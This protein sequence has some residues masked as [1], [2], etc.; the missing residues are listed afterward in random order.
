MASPSTDLSRR[1]VRVLIR[2]RPAQ[3]RKIHP[4]VDQADAKLIE[5]LC[6]E[7]SGSVDTT[8][9]FHLIT[10][11]SDRKRSER[12]DIVFDYGVPLDARQPQVKAFDVKVADSR[13]TITELFNPAIQPKVNETVEWWRAINLK[14][15]INFPSRTDVR[16]K[17]RAPGVALPV[18]IST[19]SVLRNL[20]VNISNSLRHPWY[21]FEI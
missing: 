16:R 14:H 7:L 2:T 8:N 4:S 9:I 19:F 5:K 3:L 17:G 21:K 20:N 6:V 1:P 13:L 10:K 18:S 12:V 11:I 15:G